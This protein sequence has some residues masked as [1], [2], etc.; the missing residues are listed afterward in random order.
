MFRLHFNIVLYTTGWNTSKYVEIN[1]LNALNFIL[2]YFSFTMASICFG[3]NSAIL[4]ERL[5]PFL[6]H[7]SVN[8][9]GDK[10]GLLLY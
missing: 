9:V 3:K 7:F 8:M 10:S 6:S 4:R 5:C 1:Q 2:L